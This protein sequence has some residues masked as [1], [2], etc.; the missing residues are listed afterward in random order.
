MTGTIWHERICRKCIGVNGACSL[1]CPTLNLQPGWYER[2][3][4][5]AAEREWEA[6]SAGYQD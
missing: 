3:K 6:V 5:E 4:D 1:R 2:A